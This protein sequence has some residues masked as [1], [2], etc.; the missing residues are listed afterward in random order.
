MKPKANKRKPNPGYWNELEPQRRLEIT[1]VLVF[2]AGLVVFLS[3][4][5]HFRD[6]L[7][8]SPPTV[9]NWIGRPGAYLAWFL[10]FVLGWGAWVVP[11]LILGWGGLIVRKRRTPKHYASRSVGAAVLTVSF[12]TFLSLLLRSDPKVSFRAGGVVGAY[13]GQLMSMFGQAGAYVVLGCFSLV[14]LLLATDFL[15]ARFFRMLAAWLDRV[16]EEWKK[17]EKVDVKTSG[18]DELFQTSEVTPD[19]I[20]ADGVITMRPMGEGEIRISLPDGEG[21]V[22][23]VPEDYD[24]P[25]EP[26]PEHD[27]EMP[28]IRVFSTE[29]CPPDPEIVSTVP[30]VLGKSVDGGREEEEYCLP[31][32]SLLDQPDEGPVEVDH[33]EIMQNSHLLEKTLGEFGI[34]ARVVEVNQGPVITRYELTPPPGVKL[35]RITS[36]AD[37]IA[38]SLK[39]THVRMVAPVPGKAAVGVEIPNRTRRDVRIREILASERMQRQRSRLA[40]ALGKTLS[41]DPYIAD[42]NRMPHLLIAGATGSGKSVCVNSILTSIL[43]RATPDEVK[44]L[45]IDPKRGVEMKFYNDMAHLVSPL[46]IDSR[47]AAGAL[48][49]LIEEMELRYVYLHKVGAR[50]VDS[51]NAKRRAQ[52]AEAGEDDPTNQDCLPDHIPYIVVVVD[53]FGDLMMVARNEVEA[54]IVRLAQLARAVG[55]HLVI[56]TQRPSVNIITGIIKA[57]FPARIAFQVTSRVDSRTILDCMGAE[58]LLGQGDMLFFSGGAARP[59]RLQGSLITGSEVEKVCGFVKDQR[60]ADYMCSEFQVADS[61]GGPIFGDYSDASDDELYKQAVE[62]VFQAGSASTSLL[63]RRLKIGYGRAARLIDQMYEAGIV[64]PSRGSKPRKVLTGQTEEPTLFE[65]DED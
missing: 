32:L 19:E 44:F 31:P 46:V 15:F 14:A 29:I 1:A 34:P 37:N 61:P 43:C 30:T 59:V 57:N 33:D 7:F 13:F 3:L 5:S 47:R 4:V 58:S 10:H 20:P 65:P 52:L 2:T 41:G 50:D 51:Y 53:E 38:L 54:M 17:R 6:N 12:A 26:D 22:D 49:W 55:I 27:P 9:G 8:A 40:I 24:Q 56:A 21:E 39:A 18:D 62:I 36:L 60:K 25:E 42:L 63:Q 16:K 64:G 23:I 11:V 35:S 45:L 28:R 48:R